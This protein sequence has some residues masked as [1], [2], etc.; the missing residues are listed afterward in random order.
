MNDLVNFYLQEF[1]GELIFRMLL[2]FVPAGIL[3]WV[4]FIWGKQKFAAIKIQKQDFKP[5]K[6]KH[7]L[8][9]S[10]INRI[11][12]AGVTVGIAYLFTQ[13]NYTLAYTD[14]NQYGLW[15]LILSVPLALL[16]HDLYFYIVHR[17][18]H[19][20]LLMRP[21]HGV[22]HVSLDPTPFAGYSF[23]LTETVIE[24]AYL[25]FI[26]FLVPLHPIAYLILNLAILSFNMYGHLGYEIMPKWWVTNPL[27]KY[28]NT[29]TNHNM[30]HSKFNWNFGLYTNIWDRIF[31]THHPKYE[32]TFLSLKE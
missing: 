22:H 17:L 16:T 25:V 13:T 19:T 20:R 24:Y 8:I 21:V 30:H 23:H 32:Q 10:F 31:K 18:M 3:F 11:F 1:P 26:I 14:I 12:L 29:P 7:E 15:Y 27:T 6:V 5:A 2:F 28:V 4:F 9:Y